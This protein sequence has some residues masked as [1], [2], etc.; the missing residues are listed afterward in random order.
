MRILRKYITGFFMIILLPINIF[1]QAYNYHSGSEIAEIAEKNMGNGFIEFKEELD[2]HHNTI[3]HNYS[4]AF[5]LTEHDA[6]MLTRTSYNKD[7]PDIKHYHYQ[8]YHKGLQVEG[9]EYIV[10]EKNGIAIWGNGKIIQNIN[11]SEIPAISS[12]LALLTAKLKIEN[13]Y[14][15]SNLDSSVYKLVYKNT[16][17]ALL[18]KDNYR[19]AY[20]YKLFAD[21]KTYTAYV[22]AKSG[23][24]LNHTDNTYHGGCKEGTVETMYNGEQH[25]F[26]KE[27]PYLI[28][29]KKYVLNEECD[30]VTTIYH[31]YYDGTGNLILVNTGSNN[32]NEE[33]Y[34][35]T[36]SAHWAAQKAHNYFLEVFDRWSVDHEGK[37]IE[38][39]IGD[40]HPLNPYYIIGA[41]PIDGKWRIEIKHASFNPDYPE[42]FDWP[43]ALDAIGHEFTH[44]VVQYTAE[45]NT[46]SHSSES[47]ALAESFCDIFGKMIE[48]WADSD[49]FSWELSH[50]FVNS[51]EPDSYRRSFVNPHKYLDAASYGDNYWDNVS[52]IGDMPYRRA[53]V[54]NHWFYLLAEGG[55]YNDI[56][57][58]GI[59]KVKAAKIAYSMLDNYLISNSNFL[60]ARNASIYAA[61]GMF[62]SCSYEVIQTI[63]AWKAVNVVDP[64]GMDYNIDVDCDHLSNY[65][66]GFYIP[67]FGGQIFIEPQ[68]VHYRAINELTAD[69][70]ISN[71]GPI[72]TF[73]AGNNIRLKEGFSSGNN[74][75]A[76]L[77]SCYDFV[78][79]SY[80][81]NN[82]IPKSDSYENELSKEKEE[83]STQATRFSSFPNPF[84]TSTT[85]TFSLQQASKV[86]IYI[87][88]SYGQKVHE[89]FN[90]ITEAG[91]YDIKLD[92]SDLQPGLYFCTMET[93]KSREV[94]KIVKM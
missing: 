36:A 17:Q 22:D 10:H 62:G 30:G 11:I 91:N 71:D 46:V 61:I 93:N 75:R 50:Q 20:K 80:A 39:A 38:V 37:T 40:E 16:N 23:N 64:G 5:G 54:Q 9:G 55:S 89:V 86:N 53:G 24:I 63:N 79:K 32:W 42:N 35:P 88:N 1:G 25:F 57:V 60:D 65:H 72:V 14:K 76:Y 78:S 44:G 69:C 31:P 19:L 4:H 58:N 21:S 82:T 41:K 81:T 18:I 68:P 59:G 8:Q 13:E 94:V 49:N 26:T 67:I 7:I 33:E 83:T 87:N 66:E 92:G 43:V 90:N 28:F 45:L 70:S 73:S 74:F 77:E 34:K 47:Y 2:L 52:D 15:T 29:G 56:T 85:I 12:E 27:K 84:T 48:W 51:T 6:M 3:F